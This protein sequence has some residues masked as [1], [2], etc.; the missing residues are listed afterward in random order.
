[1]VVTTHDRKD[2]II[3][4][5]PGTLKTGVALFKGKKF[6]SAFTLKASP[7]S[8]IPD[9]RAFYLITRLEEEVLEALQRRK[10][11]LR[12]ATLVYESPQMFRI[13]GGLLKI[14]PVV[15]MAG[16][17]SL[18]G[19]QLGMEVMP[20]SVSCVKTGFTGRNSATKKSVEATM[21]R[22]IPA[23]GFDR[24]DHEY[25]AVSVGVYHLDQVDPGCF[26]QPLPVSGF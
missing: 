1:M 10:G 9:N 16:M 14:E 2:W 3:A 24:T 7:L 11:D 25:D 20:Y 8:K 4:V 22:L 26:G 17:L 18:W 21:R 15:R 13:K 12:G 6:V 19:L 5:D 23:V